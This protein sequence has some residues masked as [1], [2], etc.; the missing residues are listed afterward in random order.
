M[1]ETKRKETVTKL[2]DG[3]ALEVTCSSEN[4]ALIKNASGCTDL[5]CMAIVGATAYCIKTNSENT[6]SVLYTV[7]DYQ[8]YTTS[9]PE[10]NYTVKEIGNLYHANGMAYYN[11]KLYVVGYINETNTKKGIYKAFRVSLSGTCEVTY[12]M[13]CKVS[14]IS[15]Y[16][17]GKFI[18]RADGYA[19]T[20]N[21]G[22]IYDCFMI[23]T[24]DD[25]VFTKDSEFYV[26]R[27]GYRTK[28]DITYARNHLIVPT[29]GE[30][31]NAYLNNKILLY[32][33]G[34]NEPK[35]FEEKAT[36]KVYSYYPIDTVLNLNKTVT[37]NYN[38]Y[39]V[40][41]PQLVGDQIVFVA[42]IEQTVVP[43]S[44][45][46]FQLLKGYAIIKA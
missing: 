14:A 46:G 3:A 38:K 7:K 32:F 8:K 41:S 1:D 17:N 16:K 28:Q 34:E 39:E 2:M 44:A 40:E 25:E 12:N 36:G 18:L 13:P 31:D 45:D 4:Y 43:K 21:A 42:N 10:S 37:Q 9:N 26:K 15:Y 22:S 23:G 27:G 6:R 11:K 19:K 20:D 33:I 29:T 24:F 35:T 30:I 5:G